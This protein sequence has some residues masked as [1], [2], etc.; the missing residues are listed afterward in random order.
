MPSLGAFLKKDFSE[1][2]KVAF[3]LLADPPLGVEEIPPNA[4]HVF[5]NCIQL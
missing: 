2:R 1:V 3:F 4:L 5:S